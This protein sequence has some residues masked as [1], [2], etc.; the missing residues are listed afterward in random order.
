MVNEISPSVLSQ[1]FRDSQPLE[2]ATQVVERA[3]ITVAVVRKSYC[4]RMI[5]RLLAGK[6]GEGEPV[7]GGS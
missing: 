2:Y 1:Q 5:T 6:M 7:C 3:E 4:D